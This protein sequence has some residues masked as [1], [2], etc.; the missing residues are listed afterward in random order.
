M[1]FT[2]IT[3][4][5]PEPGIG[6]MTLNRPERLNA[7]NLGMLDEFQGLFSYLREHAEIR[8]L[9]ITGAG[10]GFCAGADLKD[11]RTGDRYASVV[12]S[13]AAHLIHIQKKYAD[14][15]LEMRR[16]PQPIIA[17]VNGTAAGGGM[18]LALAADIIIAG[19]SAA[20]I[21]SFI[22]IGLSGGELGSS[23]FLPRAVGTPRASEILMT[24]RTVG[25]E[26]AERIGLVSRK[27]AGEEL[28]AV[29]METAR[30]MIAKSTMGLRLTKEAMNFNIDAPTLESAIE[31]ENKNQSI[32]IFT[33]DFLE[34]IAAFQQR[35]K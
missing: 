22:N 17:A 15:I 3:F 31:M 1:N 21:P 33:P 6:L 35:K 20:F 4:Q 19:E 18:C 27:V 5:E 14:R 7:L 13:A 9:I 11:S 30:R 8:V 25:A 12:N 23:Y 2:T 16:L 28:M 24:G 34:A 29:A 26:E 10:R 32:C